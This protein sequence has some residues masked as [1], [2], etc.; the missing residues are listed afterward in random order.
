M[1]KDTQTGKQNLNT[2]DS[3]KFP[4]YITNSS[5]N[6]EVVTA[7]HSGSAEV[8]GRGQLEMLMHSVIQKAFIV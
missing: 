3:A 5:Q 7:V 1:S 6:F 2:Q 4:Y 8:W